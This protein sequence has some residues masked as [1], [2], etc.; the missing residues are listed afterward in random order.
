MPSFPISRLRAVTLRGPRMTPGGSQGAGASVTL[1]D[2]ARVAGVH[3]GTASRALNQGTRDLV[4][5]E[6]PQRVVAAAE[7]LGYRPNPIA[8]VLKTSQSHTIGVLVP[9][10][11]NPLSS[12]IVRGIQDRLGSPL[13]CCAVQ[14]IA[15]TL[16][17]RRLGRRWRGA[18]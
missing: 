14:S 11:K 7:V 2:V 18:R 10:L 5:R 16:A 6:T 4:N 3:P 12:P 1:R 15:G 13:I 9:E 17:L 8:R